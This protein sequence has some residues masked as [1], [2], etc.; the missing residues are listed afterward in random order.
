VTLK[1]RLQ[2]LAP[3]AQELEHYREMCKRMGGIA[4]ENGNF[5][6]GMKG[7][8]DRIDRY[9]AEL[10]YFDGLMDVCEKK[11]ACRMV[12][13]LKYYEGLTWEQV[14]RKMHYSDAHVR[15]LRDQAIGRLEEAQRWEQMDID[16]VEGA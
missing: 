12:I 11:A 15:R 8:L 3:L 14:S 2:N 4:D 13:R 6:E 16:D 1:E 9:L 7:W 10:E 5:N